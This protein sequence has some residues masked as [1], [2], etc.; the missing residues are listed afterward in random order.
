MFKVGDKLG[1]KWG[2]FGVD[3]RG[4]LEL[5]FKWKFICWNFSGN[6]ILEFWKLGLGGLGNVLFF[7]GDF[8]FHFC[9][10]RLDT[11]CNARV[12]PGLDRFQYSLLMAFDIL[13]N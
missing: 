11:V 5:V 1:K 10:P 12:C 9:E 7:L 13:Q 8:L 2:M 4:G 6:A 3:F